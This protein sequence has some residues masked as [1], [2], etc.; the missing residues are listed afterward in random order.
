LGSIALGRLPQRGCSG[1][2]TSGVSAPSVS[3][4]A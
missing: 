1:C 3:A 2:L 4:C